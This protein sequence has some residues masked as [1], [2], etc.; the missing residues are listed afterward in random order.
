MN[1][2]ETASDAAVA[3][4]ARDLDAGVLG[5]GILSSRIACGAASLFVRTAAGAFVRTTPGLDLEG[6][7]VLGLLAQGVPPAEAL[8]DY[9]GPGSERESWQGGLITAEGETASRTGSQVRT[10]AGDWV[11]VEFVCFGLGLPGPEVIRATIDAME[12]TR[13]LVPLADRIIGALSVTSC[14]SHRQDEGPGSKVRFRSAALRM[15]P[16]EP[17]PFDPGES[18]PPEGPGG[19]C[20]LR[21]DDCEAPSAELERLLDVTI[22]ERELQSPEPRRA[23]AWTPSLREEV[24]ES[25]RLWA[26]WASL[27]LE[28]QGTGVP[29]RACAQPGVDEVVGRSVQ[30]TWAEAEGGPEALRRWARLRHLASWED[31]GPLPGDEARTGRGADLYVECADRARLAVLRRSLRRHCVSGFEQ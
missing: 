30:P 21:V 18:P 10:W 27:G 20:D 24:A 6:S 3:I 4:V 13:G 7:W 23:L 16:V 31:H 28:T 11:G 25:L 26:K 2:S 19:R 8:T 1:R 15:E 9:A 12:R 14:L 22:F 5:A 17:M 29:R